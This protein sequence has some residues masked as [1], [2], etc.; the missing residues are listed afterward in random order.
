[1]KRKINFSGKIAK[2]MFIRFIY[3]FLHTRPGIFF[4]S[5]MPIHEK[6]QII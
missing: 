2:V 1:M 3:S 5:T 6:N 4:T